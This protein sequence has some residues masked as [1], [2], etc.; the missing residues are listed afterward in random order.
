MNFHT[1]FKGAGR[2]LRT[3]VSSE[4]PLL[5]PQPFRSTRDAS[6]ERLETKGAYVLC[7][8][9]KLVICSQN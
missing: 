8:S 6:K 4:A 7:D 9:R 1:H 3:F 2:F 5:H